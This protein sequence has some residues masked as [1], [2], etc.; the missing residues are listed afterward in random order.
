MRKA[1]RPRSRGGEK[2]EEEV[3]RAREPFTKTVGDVTGKTGGCKA[4]NYSTRLRYLLLLLET[5]VLGDL[6]IPVLSYPLYYTFKCVIESIYSV[7][8]MNNAP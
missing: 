7:P 4:K 5:N 3:V 2:S 8:S 1:P 6:D